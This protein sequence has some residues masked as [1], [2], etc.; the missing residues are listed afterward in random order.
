V[1]KA[2]TL[3]ELLV[4]IAIIAILAGILFP[5]LAQAQEKGRQAACWSNLRQLALANQLYAAD[6]DSSFV[7]AA[8][9][10]LTDCCRW[11]GVRNMQGRFEPRAGAL[12]PY[13]KEGGLL[14]LCPSFRAFGGFDIGTGGYV[15]NAI[16]VGSRVWK[17]GYTA[18]LRAFDGSLSET[19]IIKPTETAMF[20]DGALDI[21]TGLVEY[22]FLIAPPAV[23]ARIP[24]AYYPLDPSV[25]FRH[26]QTASVAFV[27]GHCKPLKLSTSMESSGAYPGANPRRNAIGWFTPVEGD[28]FYDPE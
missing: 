6:W 4:V 11:F 18:D 25:H 21:G 2:F 22:A 13:L 27:D 7:P 9:R 16:G 17:E 23:L 20:A 26:Q 15:Y 5:V 3:I 8:P 12:V 24:N 14:R 28:T 1:R 19:E 10:F